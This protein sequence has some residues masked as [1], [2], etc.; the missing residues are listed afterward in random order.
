MGTVFL[1]LL[2]VIQTIVQY[3]YCYDNINC[4]LAAIEI[5]GTASRV[6]RLATVYLTPGSWQLGKLE[7]SN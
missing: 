7:H 3:W 2:N 4:S 6:F 1:A 5:K